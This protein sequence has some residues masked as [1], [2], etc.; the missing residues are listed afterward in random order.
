M[1]AAEK[2]IR[3]KNGL[4][5]VY[6]GNGKGK[7]S[8]A[9]GAAVRAAGYH[10]KVIMIQFIKGSWHYGEIDGAKLLAPYFTLEQMGKGFYKIIDDNLP[11]EEHKKAAR[12]GIERA[13]EV[14]QGGTYDIVILDE[15][16]NALKTGL[17]TLEEMER[18]IRAKKP[19]SHLILTGRKAHPKIIEMADLVTEMREIKHPFQKG[20]FAQKGIDY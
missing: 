7:T 10:L 19:N 8:A 16:N 15:I 6:T 11:E 13:I 5:I 18:V 12:A 4:L 17:I 2:K 14:L 3:I 1:K 9:L 20:K